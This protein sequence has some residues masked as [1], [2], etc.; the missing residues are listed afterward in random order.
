MFLPSLRYW[1][2]G[3]SRV[4]IFLWFYMVLTDNPLGAQGHHPFLHPSHY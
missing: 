3:V 2:S 1:E 4:W